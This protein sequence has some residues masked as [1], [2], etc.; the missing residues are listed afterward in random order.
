M[1]R[2]M[3]HVSAVGLRFR[4]QVTVAVSRPAPQSI[5]A[6]RNSSRA[7]AIAASAHYTKLV[8]SDEFNGQAGARPSS[9]KWTHDLGAYGAPDNE[10]QTYT[11]STTK[12]FAR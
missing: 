2:G 11:S 6:N 1:R 9:S 12:R 10:L 8:W 3:L 5:Q 7:Q 4:P